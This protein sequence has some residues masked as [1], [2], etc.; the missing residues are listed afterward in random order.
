MVRV[1]PRAWTVGPRGCFQDEQTQR[2]ETAIGKSHHGEPRP[3]HVFNG[4][5]W[6]GAGGRK[7]SESSS[8]NERSYHRAPGTRVEGREGCRAAG[9]ATSPCEGAGRF[10]ST[11]KGQAE[12]RRP[13]QGFCGGNRGHELNLMSP[14]GVLH[15]R[16]YKLRDRKSPHRVVST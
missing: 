2:D 1:I 12:P 7:A 16:P 3:C 11:V 4:G 8:P 10:H 13:Y 14:G 9:R 5:S 6:E 15:G